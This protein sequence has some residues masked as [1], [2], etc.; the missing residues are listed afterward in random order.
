MILDKET[1]VVERDQIVVERNQLV[2]CLPALKARFAHMGELEALLEQTEQENTV[3]SQEA[4]QLH[5]ELA[6]LKVK[7]AKLQD[8]VTLAAKREF[9]SMEK[10]NNLEANLC[11]KTEKAA[12]TEEKRERT[13]ERLKRVME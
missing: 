6:E 2:E 10:I 13:W 1:L 8:A 9:A 4:F 5:A 7:W 12:T 3:H 11:S